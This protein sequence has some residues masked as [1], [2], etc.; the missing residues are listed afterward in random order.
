MRF[1]LPIVSFW[2]I[3]CSI[4]WRGL[5][6]PVCFLSN[7]SSQEKVARCGCM[8]KQTESSF[9]ASNDR[10]KVVVLSETKSC[11][12]FDSFLIE[13]LP[14]WTVF[15]SYHGSATDWKINQ[16]RGVNPR[17][18][19]RL[20]NLFGFRFPLVKVY[21]FWPIFGIPCTMAN[22]QALLA[23]LFAFLA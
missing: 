17:F 5:S 21:L 7:V 8:W 16:I 19:S 9:R 1:Q 4:I 20:I 23:F 15:P 14:K 3:F 22:F 6:G 2:S 11:C 12:Y 18:G 10:W 13:S